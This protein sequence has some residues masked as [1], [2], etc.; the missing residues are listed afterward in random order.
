MSH[1]G[2]DAWQ[3]AGHSGLSP[4]LRMQACGPTP[5]SR[6]QPLCNALMLLL[7]LTVALQFPHLFSPIAMKP[8]FSLS[9]QG[10]KGLK[11]L[12]ALELVSGHNTP[13][14]PK[15]THIPEEAV[16]SSKR[17]LWR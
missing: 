1:V 9:W 11:N 8:F 14:F 5:G 12:L 4:H 15:E 13:H 16:F 3:R 7:N 6:L 17:C 2:I 10:R